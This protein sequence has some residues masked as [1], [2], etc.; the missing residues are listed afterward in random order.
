VA[1]SPCVVLPKALYAVAA[2]GRD[3]ETYSKYA[4]GIRERQY[5]SRRQQQQILKCGGSSP[6]D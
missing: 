6:F 3:E 1:K 5:P 4:E 2:G